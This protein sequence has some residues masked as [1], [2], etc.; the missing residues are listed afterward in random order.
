MRK[1]LEARA[2]FPE[3]TRFIS[4]S[5]KEMVVWGEITFSLFN[6]CVY[7]M[8]SKLWDINTNKWVEIIGK[9]ETENI[10]TNNI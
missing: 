10:T 9:V 2:M 4:F 1:V 6:C 8:A 5:G 3:G 7:C